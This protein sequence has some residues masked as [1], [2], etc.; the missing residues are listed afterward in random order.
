MVII[1]PWKRHISY[2]N[3]AVVDLAL[4]ASMNEERRRYAYFFLPYKLE[5]VNLFVRRGMANK[6]PLH[7]LTD[8]ITSSYL[9]GVEGSYFYGKQY[10]QLLKNSEFQSHNSQ[11]LEL[12]QNVTLLKGHIDGFLLTR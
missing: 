6:M 11:V 4:G 10:Q 9:I 2:T 12:E 1:L 7:S 3:S 5:A 8:H